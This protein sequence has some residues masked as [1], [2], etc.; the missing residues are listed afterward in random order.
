MMSS[1]AG[2]TSLLAFYP[3]LITDSTYNSQT[4]SN[5][6]ELISKDTQ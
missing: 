5:C 4:Y 3:Q 6:T 2:V 1:V